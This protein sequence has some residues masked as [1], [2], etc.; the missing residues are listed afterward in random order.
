MKKIIP[1]ILLLILGFWAPSAQ[2][3]QEKL[4][5]VLGVE[6]EMVAKKGII[7]N[8]NFRFGETVVISDDLTGDVYAAG[9]EVR[10]DGSVDG[11]LLV[12]GGQV[13]INGN[14]TQDLRVLGGSVII[15][16][17]V[18]KN[19]SIL[20]GQVN[21]GP[22][23]LVK[24]SLVGGTGNADLGGSI[25]GGTWL[26]TGEAVLSSDHG[27]QVNLWAGT[28]KLLPQA[29]IDG[30]LNLQ[31]SQEGSFDDQSGVVTGNKNVKVATTA[32]ERERI[33]RQTK[34]AMQ[35]FGLAKEFI[36][37]LMAGLTGLVIIY[38][39]PKFSTKLTTLITKDLWAMLGWGVISLF[40]LPV[41]SL[42][43]LITIVGM[44]LASILF[45]LYLLALVIGKYFAALALGQYLFTK[46]H[47]SIADSQ[48]KQFLT[49]LVLISL[50]GLIPLLG[51]IV[52]FVA[53][54]IGLGSLTVWLKAE[55]N[56]RHAK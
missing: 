50:I 55:I 3:V 29:K 36:G 46:Y 35:S 18:E 1:L 25:L 22:N 16:G 42:L 6:Q 54:V 49:G 24:G 52:K 10:I 21:F 34:Q 5:L 27:D 8:P 43:L 56:A 30:D 20:A 39:F 31:L 44:P 26:G 7:N 33:E 15:N 40:I 14:V 45:L 38:L 13:I 41:I 4:G 11:D 37:L 47:W 19:V 23:S 17:Q 51:A 53:L 9:G 2:A 28:V 48:Q 32:Q 12:A